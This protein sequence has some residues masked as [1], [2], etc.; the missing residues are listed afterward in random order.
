[1]Q[2]HSGQVRG[3][4]RAPVRWLWGAGFRADGHRFLSDGAAPEPTFLPSALYQMH[5]STRQ[6]HRAVRTCERAH[7]CARARVCGQL[8]ARARSLHLPLP[9]NPLLSAPPKKGA[10]VLLDC[11]DLAWGFPPLPRPCPSRA[12]SR[13][14]FPA[15]PGPRVGVH[16]TGPW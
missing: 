16:R 10:T 2:E 1:M 11:A 3:Q 8:C 15:L 5:R 4:A 12:A 7:A 9:E 6:T 14:L 13:S